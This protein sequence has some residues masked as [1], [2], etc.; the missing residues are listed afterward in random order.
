LTEGEVLWQ[1]RSELKKK[2][3][4]TLYQR[5]LTNQGKTFRGYE[6]LWSWSVKNLEAFW[7]TIWQYFD[8]KSSRPYS[9][10]L[11]REKM[12][13]AKW[14]EGAELNYGEH[15][16]RGGTTGTAIIQ[17]NEEG[18][19]TE[20]GW[21]ELKER[22]ARLAAYLR[23]QGVVKG[24]RVSGYLPNIPEAVVSLLACACIGAIWSSCSPDFGAPSVIDRFRQIE[25][26]VL[27][28]VDGYK[29]AGKRFEKNKVLREI[30]GG[31]PSLR[32]TILIPALED[33]PKI[34]GLRGVQ[35]WDEILS[36]PARLTFERLPFDHPLWVLYS[37]GTT[38]PPKPIVHGHGG[39]LLEH[40]KV[41][42]LHND[43]G[44][45]D[46]FFWF[47]STGWMMWNY[48]VGGLLLGA[49]IILYD[50]SPSFPDL[51]S[52]WSLAEI[53]G[54][55]FFGTS[56]AYI[57]SCM[58]EGIQPG[59]SHD[60]KRLRGVGST[61]SPLSAE[62][63]RWVYGVKP[64]L[65]LASISGGTDLCTAFVAGCPTLPVRAGEIQCRCLG[66]DVRSFDDS[67][68]EVVGEMGELVITKPMPSMP[69]FFW[70]DTNGRRY[71]ESYFESFPGVWR[72]GDWIEVTQ[73]GSC[74][75]YGRSDATLKRMGVRMGSG[76]IYRIVE[77]LPEVTDS[78]VIDLEG[79]RGKAYMPLF[80][81]LA[82]GRR[83]DG[84]LTQRIR[85]KIKEEL[86]P[87][88]V[89]D[90]IFSVPDIPRTLSG[91]KLEV[92][93]KRIFLGEVPDEALNRDS[94]SNPKSID[95]FIKIAKELSARR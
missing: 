34:G 84:K 2:A 78:L 20:V 8:V 65:W 37:S 12:P 22:T 80:V 3:K 59:R 15:V 30:Q 58:K 47:T 19:K 7:E 13:G 6:D 91:K 17:A 60:L 31:L 54:M 72:H 10:V 70:G 74:I 48:L 56:A 23:S 82:K 75:I 1:P 39:I 93:V 46:R 66:A 11:S 92:P 61:G 81:V 77:A 79:L 73:R 51:N 63:F 87:R 9:R 40:L 43:L 55:T 26:K 29:Y 89:P 67:G 21:A 5:W 33:R 35:P 86:S 4:I 27:I 95:R 32:R 52:L 24:D 85:Q 76:E 36:S 68:K 41:L 42:S 49:T 62:G 14:F 28:A 18:E 44:P 50:G 71:R 57:N 25:P 88:Y 38:G 16:L 83:L 94:L 64:D 90:E 53:T 45:Q 69:L